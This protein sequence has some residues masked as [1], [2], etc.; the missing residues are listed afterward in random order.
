MSNFAVCRWFKL[1]L[2]VR[3][4]SI[5]GDMVYDSD[6]DITL[7]CIAESGQLYNYDTKVL[8]AQNAAWCSYTGSG[9]L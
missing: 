8:R 5:I 4:T 1:T 3:Y 9:D 2:Y 6:S 7:W